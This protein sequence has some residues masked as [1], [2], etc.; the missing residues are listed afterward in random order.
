[1][2]KRL[3]FEKL[4]R[5]KKETNPQPHLP[6]LMRSSPS[7]VSFRLASQSARGS[8]SCIAFTWA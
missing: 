1:M 3:A 4:T 7:Q 5:S 6:R 2:L 8:A